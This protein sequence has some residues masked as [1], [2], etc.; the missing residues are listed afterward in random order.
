MKFIKHFCY[1]YFIYFSS[2]TKDEWNIFI[3]FSALFGSAHSLP[4]QL[5][6]IPLFLDVA[7]DWV[8]PQ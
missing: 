8:F 7:P 2:V 4:Q 1:I 5:H 3:P 6:D